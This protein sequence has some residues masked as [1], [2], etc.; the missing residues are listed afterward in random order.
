MNRGEIKQRISA[1]INDDRT[2]PVF[3][4][5]AQLNTLVDEA[6]QIIAEDSRAIKRSTTLPLR[7]GMQFIYL[8]SVAPDIMV[9]HRIWDHVNS[10]RL[11]ATTM[12]ELDGY[13]TRW[14][15]TTGSAPEFWYPVSWDLVGV[16]PKPV[17]PGGTMRI[18]YI[19]WPRELLDDNDEPEFPQA[20]HNALVLWGAYMSLLKKW[21]ANTAQTVFQAFRGQE[22]M[23]KGRSG[24]NKISSRIMQRPQQQVDFPSGI[25]LLG[26]N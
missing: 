14:L 15:N 18:D 4:T 12:Q 10:R 21:D 20:T 16:F 2:S 23:A 1:A 5:D 6:I 9:P 22:A 11:I 25:D 8:P 7:P 3:V 26:N 19:A 17:S 13:Q 24:I